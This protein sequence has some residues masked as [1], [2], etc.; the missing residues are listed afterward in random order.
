M[1]RPQPVAPAGGSHDLGQGFQG[2]GDGVAPLP[3]G[4]LGRAQLQGREGSN[5]DHQPGNHPDG[6]L[7]HPVRD[8]VQR[9]VAAEQQRKQGCERDLS[10]LVSE[11]PRATVG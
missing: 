11:P 5:I 3:D 9:L 4:V 8:V 1:L 2:I 7:A 10:T 6:D